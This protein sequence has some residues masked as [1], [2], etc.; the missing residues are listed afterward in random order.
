[1]SITAVSIHAGPSDAVPSNAELL[2]RVREGDTRSWEQLVRRFDAVVWARV[3][4]YRLQEADAL[5]AVQMTW[6]RL[7]ENRDRIRCPDGLR[8]WLAT[9][10]G[11]ECLRILRGGKRISLGLPDS[12][13]QLV[14]VGAGPEQRAVQAETI[15]LLRCL[16]AE[17]APDRRELLWSLFIESPPSYAE[18]ARVCGIPIG[19]IGPT[20]GRALRELRRRLEEHGLGPDG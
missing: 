15:R 14:E 11:R 3:R 20:R 1:M 4:L 12:I 13:E 18:L 7:A 5:D 6:L 9:T 10:A 16:V 17:L 2:S 19:S 8:G